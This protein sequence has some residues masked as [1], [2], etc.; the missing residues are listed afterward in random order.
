[1][2]RLASGA[3]VC[4][5]KD[6]TGSHGLEGGSVAG[7]FCLPSTVRGRTVSLGFHFSGGTLSLVRLSGLLVRDTSLSLVVTVTL[8]VLRSRSLTV[9]LLDLG[10]PEAERLWAVVV[11]LLS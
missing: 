9:V 3:V 2:M 4:G 8:S 1:M 7:S 5:N 6:A 10:F 11:E